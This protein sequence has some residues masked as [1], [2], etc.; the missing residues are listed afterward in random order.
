MVPTCEGVLVLHPVIV[1]RDQGLV[2]STAAFFNESIR[3]E[4][5]TGTKITFTL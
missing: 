1:S 2:G 3:R 4:A 5:M